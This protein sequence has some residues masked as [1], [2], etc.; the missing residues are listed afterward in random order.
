METR[1]IKL[2]SIQD[3][4]AKKLMGY[5]YKMEEP[6]HPWLPPVLQ[7]TGYTLHVFIWGK[8]VDLH[9]FPF[10]YLQT[11]LH[12]KCVISLWM[13]NFYHTHAV[14]FYTHN[15]QFQ[16][17]RQPIRL[18]CQDLTILF[19]NNLVKVYVRDRSWQ[20]GPR[21]WCFA[22]LHILATGRNHYSVFGNLG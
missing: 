3:V 9:R 5:Y 21:I 10:V 7:S 12:Y 16:K 2:N 1:V 11:I 4:K 14:Q 8:E 20:D 17:Q 19:L 6:P 15:A 18:S 13:E 22:P